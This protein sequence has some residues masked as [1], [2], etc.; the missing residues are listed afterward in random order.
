MASGVRMTPS[1]MHW[2]TLGTGG[3]FWYLAQGCCVDGM[4]SCGAVILCV[5]SGCVRLVCGE[6]MHTF[7]VCACV[8]V[9]VC[10]VCGCMQ[11]DVHGC[12]LGAHVCECG[13]GLVSQ[14]L[15]GRAP[16]RGIICAALRHWH[17]EDRMSIPHQ[18]T[19]LWL[20]ASPAAGPGSVVESLPPTWHKPCP[21]PSIRSGLAALCRTVPA[22]ACAAGEGEGMCLLNE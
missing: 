19:T 4:P 1:L 11:M 5:P 18:D 7:R 15:L 16:T 12:A 2:L 17:G 10:I 9:S 20:A 13:R 6:G 8:C 14:S 21:L 3:G 22:S